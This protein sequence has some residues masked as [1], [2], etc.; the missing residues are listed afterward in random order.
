MRALDRFFG[1]PPLIVVLRLVAVSILVGIL[2]EALD[3][4]PLDLVDSAVRFAR[5]LYATGFGT[6]ERIGR[7]FMLGA[8]VVLPIWLFSRLLRAGNRERRFRHPDR[9]W[10][11]RT[12]RP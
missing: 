10:T 4:R 2:M 5:E 6:I 1:G 8:V 11:D 3:L 7:Y 12:E 9:R